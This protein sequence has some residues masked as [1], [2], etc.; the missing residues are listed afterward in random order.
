LLLVRVR[1]IRHFRYRFFE[2]FHHGGIIAHRISSAEPVAV[3]LD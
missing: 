2:R 3:S 1:Q